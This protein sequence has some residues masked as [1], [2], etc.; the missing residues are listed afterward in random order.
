MREDDVFKELYKQI[1]TY[2]YYYMYIMTSR[3]NKYNVFIDML[4]TD[5]KKWERCLIYSGKLSVVLLFYVSPIL[6]TSFYSP[7][8]Q[9]D[10]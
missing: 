8:L 10:T 4:Q 5:V 3:G 2:I 7:F 6:L 1:I 9:L